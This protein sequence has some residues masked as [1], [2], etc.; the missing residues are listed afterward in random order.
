MAGRTKRQMEPSGKG[1]RVAR[2]TELQVE[3]SG[4]EN[5]AARGTEQQGNRAIEGGNKFENCLR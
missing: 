4:K 1:N 2:A 3:P 5:R